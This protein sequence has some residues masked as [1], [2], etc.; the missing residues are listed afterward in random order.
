LLRTHREEA[1]FQH[2]RHFLLGAGEN[3]SKKHPLLYSTVRNEGT[4]EPLKNG[5][6]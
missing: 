4:K 3:P 1:F 2:N 5:K 6:F